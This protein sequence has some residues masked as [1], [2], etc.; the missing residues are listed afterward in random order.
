MKKSLLL[1]LLVLAGLLAPLATVEAANVSPPKLTRSDDRVRVELNGQLFTEYVFKG[2]AKPFCYPLL[3][4][5]G[6]EMMRHFPM[7]TDAPGEV[8]DHPHHRSVWFTHGAVNGIDF[9]TENHLATPGQMKQGRIVN[10][11]VEPSVKGE[12]GEIRS[13]N[14]WV[15]PDGT[16]HLTDETI[17]RARQLADGSRVLDW[18]VTLQAPAGKPVVFGDTKEGSMA[19]RLPLWMTPPHKQGQHVH[20]GKGVI[21]NAEGIRDTALSEKG[22]ATWGKRS[23]WVDYHAPKDGQIYGVAMFDHPTNPRHPT[24]WHVRSYAL[25]AA[26]PFG[27]HDFENLKDQPQAGD[28]TIPAGGSETFRWRFYFHT[29]DEKT[30]QVAERFKEYA[31][32]K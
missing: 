31:A 29:G 21:V 3:A 8:K 9:W 10:V 26:N 17:I 25:F 28:L 11:S 1:P 23:A 6:T 18:E 32:G 2:A 4:S 19:I 15:G 7:K 16:V 14:E 20:D 22:N 12:V 30:S 27:K 5:D 24:W 13:R